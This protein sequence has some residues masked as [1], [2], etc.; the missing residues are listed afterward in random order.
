M[1]SRVNGLNRSLLTLLGVL[2][3]A[4]AGWDWPTASLHSAT[5]STP[6]SPRPAQFGSRPAWFWWA[7]AGVCLLIAL[8]ALVLLLAQLRTTGSVPST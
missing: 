4:A 6:R 8:L 3:L 2:L 1:S 5:G 7:V